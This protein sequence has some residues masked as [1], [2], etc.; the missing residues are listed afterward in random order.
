M[1][2]KKILGHILVFLHSISIPLTLI[3][4]FFI[5]NFYINFILLIYFTSLIFGWI[6]F[7]N[8]ILTP[9][10]NYLLNENISYDD[11]TT[12]SHIIVMFEKYTSLKTKQI[13]LALT[14]LPI[15]VIFIFLV[16]FY[17]LNYSSYELNDNIRIKI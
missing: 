1:N 10:E 9:L 16:K 12:K 8:C 6:F 4:I 13:Y 7:G 11:G 15:F 5:K 3:I 14:Y 17:M 2:L